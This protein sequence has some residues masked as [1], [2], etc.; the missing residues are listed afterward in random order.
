MAEDKDDK[1]V[2]LFQ[3]GL[4]LI[5]KTVTL[6]TMQISANNLWKGD[7]CLQYLFRNLFIQTFEK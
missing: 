4:H 6:F 5:Q 7:F 1:E 2:N 3:P